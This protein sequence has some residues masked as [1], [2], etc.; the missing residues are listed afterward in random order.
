M[1]WNSFPKLKLGKQLGQCH[2]VT[3][4]ITQRRSECKFIH[5]LQFFIINKRN[6]LFY[7]PK[8]H[9]INLCEV[10]V[11]VSFKRTRNSLN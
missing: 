8:Y 3:E 11:Q 4:M 2:V 9:F 5:M 10:Q 6:S 7:V 1:N